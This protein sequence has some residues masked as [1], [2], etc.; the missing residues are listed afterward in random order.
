MRKIGRENNIK[1]NQDMVTP[2]MM[3]E[4]EDKQTNGMNAYQEEE[5][6][7]TPV[8]MIEWVDQEDQVEEEDFNPKV[9]EVQEAHKKRWIILEEPSMTVAEVCAV[10][11]SVESQDLTALTPTTPEEL[12][13]SAS[14]REPPLWLPQL[15]PW[16]LLFTTWSDSY[17]KT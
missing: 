4:E 7:V 14:T 3:T 11:R 5:E 17:V 10:L 15:L 2:V 16:P 9:Q 8:M 6:E 1:E 13:S 12:N